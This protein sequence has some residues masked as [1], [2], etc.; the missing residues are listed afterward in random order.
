MKLLNKLKI[1]KEFNRNK[2]ISLPDIRN[3]SSKNNN[4]CN[5]SFTNNNKSSNS[6]NQTTKASLSKNNSSILLI[7]N[8]LKK[9][10]LKKIKLNNSVS[11]ISSISDSKYYFPKTN[12]NKDLVNLLNNADKII[13]IRN[14]SSNYVMEGGKNFTR[15][16]NINKR[17]EISK[18]NFT[19]NFLKKRSLDINLKNHL[20]DQA[21]I[22]FNTIYNKDYNNFI[23]FISKKEEDL[24]GKAIKRRE[25]TESKLNEE[26]FLNESLQNQIKY[27]IKLFFELQ[28][29]GKFFHQLIDEPFIYD[30]IPNRISKKFNYE[31][32]ANKIINLYETED[33]NKNLP[34]KLNKTDIFLKKY[35]QME[36]MVLFM[37]DLKKTLE[38]EIKNE[39]K[40]L[41]DELEVINQIKLQY[42]KDLKFYNEEKAS[43]ESDIE[44][45]ELFCKLNLDDI[46]NYIIELGIDVD[47]KEIIPKK[48]GKDFDEFIPYI[49]EIFKALEKKEFEINNYIDI[50]EQIIQKEKNKRNNIIKEIILNQKNS[51]KLD[52]RLSFKQL[53]EKKK[54]EKDLKTFEK[55]NKLIMKG[56]SAYK[57]PNIKH[58]KIINK[59]IVIKDDNEDDILYYSNSENNEE[60]KNK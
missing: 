35:S 58:V 30:K 17:K 59:K 25:E 52:S 47:V 29:F 31:D 22:N 49:K 32:I 9:F 7:K 8:K 6:I 37:I 23:N 55:G 60:E 10:K 39:N 27:D 46:L 43:I 48:N 51:N 20:M 21:L 34:D 38:T 42:E 11:S 24:L 44:K 13:K 1:N 36:E 16:F 12:T 33:K 2:L 4:S 54:L 3:S 50:I 14:N 5:I 28:K 15:A 45:Y 53:Q 57:Y 41:N 19:I 18:T 56:R 26:L 40:E